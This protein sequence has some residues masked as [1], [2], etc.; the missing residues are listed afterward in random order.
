MRGTHEE[1]KNYRF[2][3]INVAPYKKD[4]NEPYN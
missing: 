1:V 2:H 3:K 4:A